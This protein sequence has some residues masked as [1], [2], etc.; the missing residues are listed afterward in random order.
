[1]KGTVITHTLS[2]LRWNFVEQ[3]SVVELDKIIFPYLDMQQRE[4]KVKN[5]SYV[6]EV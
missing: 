2:Y 1:M 4:K 5:T 3:D 6:V